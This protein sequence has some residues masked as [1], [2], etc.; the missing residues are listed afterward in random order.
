MPKARGSSSVMAPLAFQIENQQIK[1]PGG[2]SLE[3]LQENL[4]INTAKIIAT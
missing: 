2:E 4:S 1:R 3:S